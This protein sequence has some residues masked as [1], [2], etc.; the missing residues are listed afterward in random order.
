MVVFGTCVVLC[1]L[2]IFGL[3]F[4]LLLSPRLVLGLVGTSFLGMGWTF[5]VW[6]ETLRESCLYVYFLLLQPD[7]PI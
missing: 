1:V 7:T 5:L 6:K 2:L 3:M 4:S